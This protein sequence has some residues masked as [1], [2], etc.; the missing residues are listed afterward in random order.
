VGSAPSQ[1]SPAFGSS[2]VA[3]A[4]PAVT[5]IA[6]AALDTAAP[7][8]IT[9]TGSNFGPAGTPSVVVVYSSRFAGS[10]VLPP[11]AA[12]AT[13]FFTA[14]GCAVVTPHTQVRCTSAPG[15]GTN[16]AALIS[17]GG[18][19]ALTVST[20]TLTY[21]S[22][23]VAGLT[24]VG[25]TAA[26]TPGGDVVLIS[27]S[28]FGPLTPA[29]GGVPTAGAVTPA[30]YYGRANATTPVTS[31]SFAAASCAVTAAHTQITC[32]TAPGSGS[33][34]RWAVVL[35]GLTSGVWFGGS[36]TYAPPVIGTYSG[37]V[38]NQQ[39][40]GGETVSIDGFNLGNNAAPINAVTYGPDGRF[41]TAT[42]CTHVIPHT[43]ISCSTSPGAGA[44]LRWI[45]NIDGQESSTPTTDYGRPIID[46]ITLEGGGAATSLATDG[47]DAVIITG[48]FLSTQAFLG[49]V[50]YGP[51]GLLFSAVNCFVST[52]HTG[53]TCT[54]VPGTGANL[55]F[56]VT[57]GGQTSTV[58]SAR[59]AYAAPT[60][61]SLSPARG[62][63][64]GSFAATFSV[65]TLSGANLGFAYTS[66]R[67]SIRFNAYGL[68]A[69]S[70][71]AFAAYRN[72]LIAGVTP[73]DAVS[74]AVLAW[75]NSL[76]VGRESSARTSV[77]G[78]HSLTFDEPEGF[79]LNREVL[80]VVDGVPSNILRFNYDAPRINNV[81]PDRL[82][83]QPGFLR[84]FLE[85]VNFCRPT[86]A[87]AG[88]A[89]VY[90][91]MLD[92]AGPIVTAPMADQPQNHQS[93]VVMAAA[94]APGKFVSLYIVVG[95][96]QSNVWN[97]SQ[98]VPSFSLTGPNA[99]QSYSSPP[100][101]VVAA[102]TI[103]ITFSIAGPVTT[104]Q[105]LDVNYGSSLRSNYAAALGV[106]M[107]TVVFSS[108][109]DAATQV[110]TP[111]DPNS[112]VNTRVLAA[113][114]GVNITFGVDVVRAAALTG[115]PSDPAS[116]AALISAVTAAAASPAAVNN[117][118]AS[119]AASLGLPPSALVAT[120]VVSQ[121]VIFNGTAPATGSASTAGGEPFSIKGVSSIAT[122]N[123][124]SIVIN[125]GG[126]ACTDTAKTQDGDLSAQ[127]GVPPG[128]PLAAQYVTYT[129]SCL[130]PAGAGTGLPITITVPGGTSRADPN[131]VF[132]YA[133]PT[134]ADVVQWAPGV[135]S[136]RLDAAGD[137]AVAAGL[138]SYVSPASLGVPVNGM[139]TT[140]TTVVVRGSNFGAAGLNITDRTGQPSFPTLTLLLG[141]AS[142]SASSPARRILA[143]AA[144]LT[145][146]AW[147]HTAVAFSVP[148]GQGSFVDASVAI[149][150]QTSKDGFSSGAGVSA[151]RPGATL[152]FVEPS[153]VS[154]APQLG[155]TTGGG[156]LTIVGAN[157]G[158]ANGNA[159]VLD[160]RPVVTVGGAPCAVP[161]TFAPLLNHTV[162]TC[163][164]PPGQGLN[165]PVVVTVAG[166]ASTSPVTY[167][168]RAPSVSSVSPTSG[169]TS[170][171]TPAGAPIIVTLRGANFGFSGAVLFTPTFPSELA[172]L[173]VFPVP[174][175]NLISWN[176]TTVVFAV[177]LT[178]TDRKSVV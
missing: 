96:Q 112:A 48:R 54:T 108:V 32:T 33:G 5:A 19:A 97:F 18:Q 65:L 62:P 70:A 158:P 122:V 3:Y 53:I 35:D 40:F 156:V 130:T 95:G 100:K 30:A 116:I 168:Y 121:P 125:I 74:V 85:G 6:S 151:A 124:S 60:I 89:N 37:V 118:T 15:F 93:A 22:P 101:T 102:A 7:S 166:Q 174:P 77:G 59:A 128:S 111:V 134:V 4:P 178:V 117:A 24:G 34:L 159:S 12:P 88:C 61:A 144:N 72:A 113:G 75:I 135:T 10:T 78:V 14:S 157:F 173:G 67:L 84:V 98:P 11:G 103:A 64:D 169:P 57:V 1:T 44:G 46:A 80:V 170:G 110:I 106:P 114:T 154:A 90:I 132:S 66:S 175:A 123:A 136:R 94:P 129:I 79:G 28:Q 39:T 86:P 147:T 51:D 137:A 109:T 140:G 87:T 9:F 119:L 91:D 38:R 52:P 163:V 165:V 13:G 177:P 126:R 99:Q 68:A 81:A 29:P 55:F 133:P 73:T 153:L 171:K 42:G 76:V 47:G 45:V 107:P 149:A 49:A 120:V 176:H 162:V 92:G 43:R 146:V 27:G 20:A 58:S 104:S 69:P 26:G 131:F 150:G 142:L 17:V 23:V 21:K 141:K 160:G 172:S 41:F 83:V 155:P 50:T 148:V 152:R 127:Y 164:V 167:T 8:L 82:N 161:P 63:T 115:T 25:A 2:L 145:V 105:V 138:Y 139:P 71:A 16:L 143:V 31:L 36:T 56:T